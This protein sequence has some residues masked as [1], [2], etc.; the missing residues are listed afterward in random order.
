MAFLEMLIAGTTA[1]G[2]FHYLRNQPNGTAHGDPNA[3]AW[4][5]I[6]AAESVDIR[7]VLLRSIYQRAGYGLM[8][9]P[10][11]AR[12]YET[13]EQLLLSMECRGHRLWPRVHGERPQ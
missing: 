8:P 10:W 11:Q 2:E 9:D 4:Q 1:I 12:F 6:A 7:I 5:I 13:A 3:V